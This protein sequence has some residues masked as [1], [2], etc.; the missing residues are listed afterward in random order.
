MGVAIRL[1]VG[2]EN[3]VTA[4][5]V[6]AKRRNR[7]ALTP[8]I[9]TDAAVNPGNPAARVQSEREVVGVNS[10]IYSARRLSGISFAIPINIALDTANQLIE[11]RAMSI[12]AYRRADRRRGQGSAESLGLAEQQGA[13]VSEV[14]KDG[15]AEKAGI[16]EQDIILARQRQGDGLESDIVRTVAAIVRSKAVFSVWRTAPPEFTIAIGETP[17]AARTVKMA[18]RRTRR[19]M[20]RKPP[21]TVSAWW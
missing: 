12:G 2:F 13:I 20:P 14:V 11:K 7:D 6:S 16:K 5:I 9:Q 17:Q 10:Q 21:P 3:T 15:P 4:G 1:P 8:F 19:T 18:K